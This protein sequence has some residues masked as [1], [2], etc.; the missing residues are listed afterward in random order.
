MLL[1]NLIRNENIKIYRRLRTWILVGI[2]LLATVLV[3]V[4]MHSRQQ[5]TPNWK[6]T[7][8]TQN[9]EMQQ[10]LNHGAGHMPAAALDGMKQSIQLNQYYI[11][12][13]INPN[14]TTGW[15]FAVTAEN[16]SGLLMAF[17]VVIA[18]DIVASEFSTGT[19]KMLLTQTATRAQILLSKYLATLLFALFMTAVLFVFSLLCGWIFFGFSEAGEPHIYADANGHIQHMSTASY[20][21]MQY[22]FLLI[23]I[24]ITATIAFM[25]SA[26]FRSST[27]AITISILAYF[28]GNTLV[29]ALSSYS[30]VKYILFANT[31]LSQ[32]VVGGPHIK[33][34]TLGFSVTMLVIYFVVMNVLS[35]LIFMKR[36]VAYT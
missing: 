20:L 4:V 31:N 26:I 1:F 28:V 24:V 21:L 7:L 11:D 27:L 29:T 3:A 2:I 19:I 35:W 22:G 16:L 12:H 32:Y 18:G 14:H 13:N 9:Q 15:K 8:I 10:Q 34:M 36:D 6:Q 17:I 30:W 23:D 5:D 33:G 25:I